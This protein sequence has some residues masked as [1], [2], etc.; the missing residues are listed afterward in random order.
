MKNIFF[1]CCLLISCSIFAQNETKIKWGTIPTE[2]LAMTS[3][4]LDTSAAAVVLEDLGKITLELEGSEVYYRYRRH[5]RIKILKPNGYKKANIVIPYYT[6]KKSA[7]AFTYLRAQVFSPDGEKTMVPNKDVI[8]NLITGNLSEKRFAFPKVTPGSILEYRYEIISP[9]IADLRDWY[10][11]EDI[12]I[13]LSELQLEIPSAFKYVYLFQGNQQMNQHGVD[14]RS[15]DIR[16]NTITKIKDNVYRIVN[17]PALRQERYITTLNDYR[18]RMRFQLKEIHFPMGNTQ[19]YL[20]SWN[21]VSNTLMEQDYFGKQITDEKN[22]DLWLNTS[23]SKIIE[24]NISE[25]EK[26]AKI[27]QY[28]AESVKW[29]N[30]YRFTS[31]T[32]LNEVFEQ[33]TGSSGE[34]NLVYLVLLRKAGIEAN[35]VLV[36]TRSHGRTIQSYPIIDQFNHVVISA[37]LDGETTLLEMGDPVKPMDQPNLNSLNY[38]GW[39]MDTE[40]PRWIDIDPPTTSTTTLATLNINE[41]GQLLGKL[42]GKYKGYSATAIRK[43]WADNNKKTDIPAFWKTKI[44]ALQVDSIFV[45]NQGDKDKSLHVLA[46]VSI[47]DLVKDEGDLLYFNPVLISDFNENVLPAESR[48]YPVDFNF[49]LKESYVLNME[50]PAGYTI[51]SMPESI[52]LDLPDNSAAYNF[53]ASAHENFIQLIS[54]ININN[55]KFPVASYDSLRELFI[56]IE[57]KLLEPIVFKK[58]QKTN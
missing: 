15:L 27:Y 5:R 47:D 18:A 48:I 12:P 2:D 20:A 19:S 11:Q 21:E 24:E 16:G 30:Q 50:I 36:S 9:R 23:T 41:K 26:A 32:G 40:V 8:D 1:Y 57:T 7:E 17:V 37:E 28:V 10:F 54:K 4:T 56:Q 43:E 45:K 31:S 25:R 58:I 55:T 52:S 13:R 35:P 46:E 34:R 33:K 39:L 14:E 38:A 29:N 44:P 3:Y 53:L 49:P 22:Y 51:E 6:R 42:Q